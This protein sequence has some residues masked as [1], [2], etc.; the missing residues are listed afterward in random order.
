MK[1]I[2]II[3]TLII[4]FLQS[5]SY[6]QIGIQRKL[7][8]PTFSSVAE[9]QTW[10]KSSDGITETVSQFSF[11]TTF[12]VPVTRNIA[13]DIIGS[14]VLSSYDDSN[15]SGLQDVK[16][17][18]V[19]MF[20]DDTFM[21]TAG[22]N[23]PSGK[24]GLNSDETL[25]SSFLS[26]RAMKFRYSR[27][28]EGFDINLGCGLARAFG[29]AAFG[30]GVGYLIKGE[31]EFLE[32]KDSKYKPGN[33]MNFTGGFDLSFKP[34]F[35]RTDL[36][37]TTYGSD[38]VDGSEV[39][40]E[41][42]R[43]VFEETAVLSLEKISLLLS[44]RYTTRG[45]SEFLSAGSNGESRKM[46][47]NRLGI[48]GLVNLGLTK[49]LSLKILG[50]TNFIGE[51][52]DGKNDATVFGFGAGFNL[53]FMKRSFIELTGKYYIGSSDSDTVDLKGA[54]DDCGFEIYVLNQRIMINRRTTNLLEQ[55]VIAVNLRN[56]SMI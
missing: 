44:G 31:Y 45:E 53:K 30:A 8:S 49:Q 41:A 51:N 48:S 5:I 56:F 38:K 40:T 17:R 47:G 52:D 11:P 29:K 33:Q 16:A 15:L 1:K 18:G 21:L 9:Y 39:F 26:D 35:L 10:E 36:T 14:A 27:L 24:S 7:F 43:F 28:G 25:V 2:S 32:D 19:A 34:I 4:I 20:A 3:S 6:A 12:K 46:Y 42:P 54:F 23:L 55:P 37:Y 13:F 22:V 50:E